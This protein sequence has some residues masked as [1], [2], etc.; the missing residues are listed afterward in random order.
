VPPPH[1]SPFVDNE[2]EGYVPD[3]A[4]TIKRLQA[5]A[6]NELLPMPGVGKEDL[7][8]PQ[9]LVAEGIID[10]TEANEAAQK[11]RKMLTLEKQYHDE[12]KMEL[13]GAQYSGAAAHQEKETVAE[14]AE[15]RDQLS[16]PD[17]KQVVEDIDTLSKVVMSRKKRRLYEAMKMGKERKKAGVDLLKERKTKIEAGEKSGK[18]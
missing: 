16:A 5:A 1:L 12:L 18:K 7:E 14:D 9:H 15:A 11:K 17:V 2:A 13:V 6:R 10:R 8:D 4:E 3:Y